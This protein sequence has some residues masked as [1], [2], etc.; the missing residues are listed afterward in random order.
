MILTLLKKQDMYGYQICQEISCESQG[1]FSLQEGSLYPILYRFL[2]K[3]YI[4]S[5]TEKVGKRRTRVYYHIEP[6]GE[7]YLQEIKKEFFNLNV[8][9]FLAL[10]FKDLGDLKNEFEK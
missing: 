8:G 10:G 1:L 9:V 6:D 7:K 2:E 3:R 4:S 5:R